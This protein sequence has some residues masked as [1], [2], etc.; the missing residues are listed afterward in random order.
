M[1]EMT[2]PVKI[3]AAAL[4]SVE[5]EPLGD[6]TLVIIEETRSG[7][8]GVGG[9]TLTTQHVKQIRQEG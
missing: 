9:Q 1:E 8:R 6:K 5:G 2:A 7:G 4:A 3:V